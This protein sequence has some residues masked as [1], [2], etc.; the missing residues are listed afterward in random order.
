MAGRKS[1]RR[2]NEEEEKQRQNNFRMAEVNSKSCINRWNV[3]LFPLS[4]ILFVSCE[5][6]VEKRIVD[7][8]Q[9][10]C[11]ND[12]SL[13]CSWSMKDATNFD[14][15]KLYVI[16]D[17]TTSDSIARAIRLRYNGGDVPDDITR[18]IFISDGKVVH[19]EDIKSLDYERSTI[20]FNSIVIGIEDRK[21]DVLLLKMQFSK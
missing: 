4:L 11:G 12:T 17:W 14:W 8:L 3:L 19:Q 20:D 16:P 7:R 10:Q 2:K 13:K 5:N 9:R 15:D 1:N 6:T 18:I 21:I